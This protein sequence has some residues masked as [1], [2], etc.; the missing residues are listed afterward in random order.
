VPPQKP[1]QPIP[2]IKIQ[3]TKFKNPDVPPVSP[4]DI[5]EAEV[6]PA[7]QRV[8]DKAGQ[9]AAPKIKNQKSR[10]T[11]HE[12]RINQS[13]SPIGNPSI[14]ES[15]NPSSISPPLQLSN[16]PG[17][18]EACLECNSPLP[19][20]RPDGGRPSKFCPICCFELPP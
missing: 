19:A 18:A 5:A 14:H 20:L 10:T 15:T 7:P 9:K 16:T 4:E 12:P 1:E 13:T 17:P 3:K 6:Q 2:Q 8:G 11:E